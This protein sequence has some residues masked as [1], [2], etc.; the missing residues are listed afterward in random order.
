MAPNPLQK[1]TLVVLKGQIIT[2]GSWLLAAHVTICEMFEN[3]PNFLLGY[4]QARSLGSVQDTVAKKGVK[5]LT[6][7]Q[8]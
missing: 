1:P 4:E 3:Q 8:L 2:R 5:F 7:R 6:Y